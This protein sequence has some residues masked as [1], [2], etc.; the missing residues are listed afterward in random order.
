MNKD[1]SLEPK[2][3]WTESKLQDSVANFI[4]ITTPNLEIKEII[5]LI[6]PWVHYFTHSSWFFLTAKENILET[7]TG[8]NLLKKHPPADTL[9][10]MELS[11]TKD[12]A[13]YLVN[14][15]TGEKTPNLSYRKEYH[16]YDFDALP[17]HIK[18]L[19]FQTCLPSTFRTMLRIFSFNKIYFLKD[20]P[21]PIELSINELARTQLYEEIKLNL[22]SLLPQSHS[23]WLSQ[24][25]IE[26]FPISLFENLNVRLNELKR[27]PKINRLYS[28]NAWPLIDDWKL[29]SIS[30]RQNH[31]SQTIGIPHALGHGTLEAF[32]QRD[33]EINSLDLYYTWGW[34]HSNSGVKKF[35]CPY[36]AGKRLAKKSFGQYFKNC[37][38]E[39]LITA[40]ARPEHLL[41]Y[42]YTPS[43]FFHYL[44]NQLYL[45]NAIQKLTHQS[46]TIRSRPKDLGWN[47]N[48]LK[49]ELNNPNIHIEYQTGKFIQ[50]LK[51]SRI[52][53]CDNTSTALIES[54]YLNHPTL[55]LIT[56]DYFQL[57]KNAKSDFQNLMR[58]GI[59]HSNEKSLL[60]HLA[61]VNHKLETWWHSEFTQ[62]CIQKFLRSQAYSSGNIRP[63]I[64]ILLK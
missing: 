46:V 9:S 16:Q 3:I 48:E 11:R 4:K 32:W 22:A 14:T 47:L 31:G 64:K 57:N 45:A 37:N 5:F 15:L 52:H 19:G 51:K 29:F 36:F 49:D 55:V 28:A 44:Q 50:R 42:P 20:K 8:C 60:A 21:I 27:A 25:A 6:A 58:C 59:Y 54:L 18:C 2:L 39:I 53:V 43:K 13:Q 33:F 23:N 10:F 26:F 34:G 63:W 1:E 61:S 62:V 17:K 40:A 35:E 12:Y 7:R 30:Q 56:D 38:K 24:R 41:E